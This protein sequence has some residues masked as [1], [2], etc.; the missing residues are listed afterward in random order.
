MLFSAL[1]SRFLPA[2]TKKKKRLE[3][4]WKTLEQILGFAIRDKEYYRLAL[5]DPSTTASGNGGK[6]A[7]GRS[8][9]TSNDNND[10]LEFLGDSIIGAVVSE[11]LYRT[12]PNSPVG[13]LS[14]QKAK[15]VSRKIGDTIAKRM[16]IDGLIQ[17]SSENFLAKDAPGN[18]L[19][20]IVGAIYLDRGFDFAH[21]FVNHKMLGIY[22]EI[23]ETQPDLG[24]NFKNKLIE[25]GL[26]HKCTV[27]FRLIARAPGPRGY[28]V[29]QVFIDN[30]PM[31]HSKGSTKK[32]SEQGAAKLALEAI[33]SD[34][35]FL[36][37]LQ[38]NG[39]KQEE[40]LQNVDA[41][42]CCLQN[43]IPARDAMPIS[44]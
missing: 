21:Q 42:S 11:T 4:D 25:W 30:Q 22:R 18:A 28:F 19:E 44:K 31:G 5:I 9:M 7:A 6:R 13:T 8:K 10:R 39:L 32:G 33:E 17:H 12:Y 26:K 34:K 2:L 20:A 27:E 1:L 40:V 37:S 15:I 41:G 24:T 38:H 16:G 14:E 36:E 43:A 29:S 3:P 35:D 23:R